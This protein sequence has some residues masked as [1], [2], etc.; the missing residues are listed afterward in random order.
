MK[1]VFLD[2]DGVLCVPPGKIRSKLNA[3][4]VKRLNRITSKSGAKIVISSTWRLP[5]K[6]KLDFKVLAD[7]LYVE[8]V[9]ADIIDKTPAHWVP[10]KVRGVNG[11]G[12]EIKEWLDT[13]SIKVE[14]FV[15]IDD[16]EDMGDLI[17]SLVLTSHKT[18]IVKKNIRAALTVLGDEN[19]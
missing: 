13:T 11:R 2:I 15:I 5:C 14:S 12:A 18:G 19:E 16:N 3:D 10:G 17:H 9:E 7:Y 8:G 4:C 1:I 6:T